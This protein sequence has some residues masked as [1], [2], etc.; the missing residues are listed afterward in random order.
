MTAGP[1]GIGAFVSGSPHSPRELV[2]RGDLLAAYCGLDDRVN[3]EREAYLSHFAFGPEMVTHYRRNGRSV[4]GYDGPVWADR[5]VLDVDR[6]EPAAALQDARALARVLL[7][8]Y[9]QLDGALPVFASGRKGY[10]LV[11]ELAHDPP[12]SGAFNATCRALA[13]G[14]ARAAGVA[15]DAGVYD[16]NRLI[17]LP[18]SRHPATGRHKVLLDLGELFALTPERIAARAAHPF[19]FDMP[20]VGGPV[21]QLEADWAEA[22]RAAA[23]RTAA[24]GV[25]RSAAAAGP[26]RAPKYLIDFFRFA[27]PEHERATTLF[28]CAAVLTEMGC[29]PAAVRALLDEPARDLGLPPAEVERQ[30]RCGVAHARRQAGGGTQE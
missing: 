18:N 11:V 25:A 5:L 23:G 19:A 17:R 27:A 7:A 24:R 13:E 1:F 29:P 30:I 8:R 9:P 12:P 2:R 6:T 22:E 14:L 26:S 21:P 3:P 16:K 28:R 20:R 15:I 4:R 10:H